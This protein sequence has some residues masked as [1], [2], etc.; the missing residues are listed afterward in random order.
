V[1]IA[2]WFHGRNQ[3][4]Q[5]ADVGETRGQA[6]AVIWS[7]LDDYRRLLASRGCRPIM[8][9]CQLLLLARWSS[10]DRFE[11]SAVT[12]EVIMKSRVALIGLLLAG[13]VGVSNAAPPDSPETVYVDGTPCN[14][15]CQSYMAWSRQT[16]AGRASQTPPRVVERPAPGTGTARSK[17]VATHD[18]FAKQAVPIAR[19]TRP[20]RVARLQPPADRA[21]PTPVGKPAEAAIRAAPDSVSKPVQD[22]AEPQ[23]A[24]VPQT[25]NAVSKPA[26]NVAGLQ[27]PAVNTPSSSVEKAAAAPEPLAKAGSTDGSRTRAIQNQVIAATALADQLTSTAAVA[28]ELK[29]M[30]GEHSSD[31]GAATAASPDDTASL[32]AL[33]MS[34]PEIKS[35]SDLAGK[36]IAIDRGRSKSSSD[37]RTALVAAGASEV[38]L[39][40]G[41]IGAIDRL[42]SGDVPAAVLTLVSADA[43]EAFPEIAGFKVFRVPL[44]PR[45]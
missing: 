5:A 17:P 25:P 2:I 39:T 26:E 38:Q 4:H 44:S 34:R 45:S 12:G 3:F 42:V 31:T 27:Q 33:V 13:S 8:K 22:V 43:A 35:V 10:I 18:R 29:A 41:E 1:R 37:V 23:T 15:F 20:D 32:V 6:H 28:P 24:A 19:Q 21:T 14:G 7:D 16:L 11:N 40:A 9:H 30:H 36:T